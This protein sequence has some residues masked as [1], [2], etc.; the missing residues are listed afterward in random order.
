MADTAGLVSSLLDREKPPVSQPFSS[1]PD[2]DTVT[3]AAE[4]PIIMVPVP[5]SRLADVYAA[6][7][8]R[9]SGEERLPWQPIAIGLW[10]SSTW[11]T[12]EVVRPAAQEFARQDFGELG[13][14]LSQIIGRSARAIFPADE[15]STEPHGP[16]P[17]Q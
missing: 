14:N 10:R 8:R 16:D 5:R 9:S 13:E 11:V 6:L 4:D 17:Q 1:K 15:R 2:A 3:T 12:R 7:G